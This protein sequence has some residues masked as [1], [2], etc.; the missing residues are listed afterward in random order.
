MKRIHYLAMVCF[1]TLGAIVFSSASLRG[2]VLDL[3]VS[4]IDVENEIDVSA[5]GGI[6]S[7]PFIVYGSV[8]R[9][10]IISYIYEQIHQ[11]ELSWIT[12][13][14]V[15]DFSGGSEGNIVL[16]ISANTDKEERQ[17]TLS[18]GNEDALLVQQSLNSY[19]TKNIA[20]Q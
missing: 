14:T 11:T 9:D 1:L 6:V 12:D 13:V 8:T 17:V 20:G 19:F 7:I 18:A 15:T 2:Q 4:Y 16:T 5:G 3:G 10:H